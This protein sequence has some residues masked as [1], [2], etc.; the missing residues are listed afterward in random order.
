MPQHGVEPGQ[1]G[2]GRKIG[3]VQRQLCHR[4]HGEVLLA[5]HCQRL[6]QLVQQLLQALG[7]VASRHGAFEQGHKPVVSC[8]GQHGIAPVTQCRRANELRQPLGHHGHTVVHHPRAEH[9]GHFR[10][11]VQADA[12]EDGLRT[13]LAR[14][15]QGRVQQQLE[16]LPVG[17]VGHA[18]VV[19]HVQVLC[20]QAFGRKLL[21]SCFFDARADAVQ[22][23]P[24]LKRF[25]DVVI[26]AQVHA[27]AHVLTVGPRG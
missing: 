21:G 14:G 16:V 25:G 19:R 23:F 11:V 24:P 26:S 17:Q 4:C 18:V 27:F 12:H 10:Q 22:Q 6:R 5:V 9:L 7:I 15:L 13:V 8:P 1:N 20:G 3:L 2:F